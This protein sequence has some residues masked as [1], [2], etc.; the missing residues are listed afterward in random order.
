MAVQAFFSWR[1]DASADDFRDSY[2]GQWDGEG[3]F[4]YN[5]IED[6][7]PEM[8][9]KMGNLACYF[10]YEAFTRDLF[11]TDYYESDGHVFRAF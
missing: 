10:N 1:P 6:C 2:C 9:E 5:I 8:I 3:D 4:A 7:Y 11:M